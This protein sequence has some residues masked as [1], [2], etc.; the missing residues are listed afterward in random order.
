MGHSGT[1]ER[2]MCLERMGRQPSGQICNSNPDRKKATM[3]NA[4]AAI[5]VHSFPLP[6]RLTYGDAAG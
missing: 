2:P 1:G 3:A 6:E 4:L 5:Q